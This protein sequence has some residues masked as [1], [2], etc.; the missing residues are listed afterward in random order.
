[1]NLQ[2]WLCRIGFHD[3]SPNHNG[4]RVCLA[5]GCMRIDLYYGITGMLRYMR[6]HYTE[7]EIEQ[8]A[9]GNIPKPL[10]L[11]KTWS[12]RKKIG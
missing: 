3:W 6:E 5:E 12:R 11:L 8:M 1:M 10:K 4:I 7:K 9:E 2:K